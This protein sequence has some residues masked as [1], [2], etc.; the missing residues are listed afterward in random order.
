MIYLIASILASSLIFVIFRIFANYKIDTFQA[1]VY[2]YFMA[3]GFGFLLYGHQFDS[4]ALSHLEWLPMALVC[5]ILFILLF[6]IIGLSSQRNGVALTSVSIKMSMGMSLLMLI[7]WNGESVTWLKII[8]IILA[9]LGVLFISIS[10]KSLSAKQKPVIWMLLL[11]FVGGG[12]LDF[13]LNYAQN[14]VLQFLP[15][16]LFSAIGFGIAGVLG[17]VLLLA[18]FARK[19]KTFAWRHV[20]AGV[21]LGVPN[22]FSIFLIMKSYQEVEWSD[23]TVL[24]VMNISIVIVSAFAGFVFFKEIFN[25]QK[26]LGLIIS[27]AAILTLYYA[28]R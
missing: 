3:F 18:A 9:L 12:I 24:A 11:L 16:S 15:N 5:G 22:F 19:Q 6:L 20:W 27:V 14:H 8:G 26:F 10:P 2:N 28:N 13:T 4:R 21:I 17:L 7:F 25:R 1:I 23:S